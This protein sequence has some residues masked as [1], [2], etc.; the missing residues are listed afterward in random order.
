MASYVTRKAPEKIDFKVNDAIINGSGVGM[1]LGILASP[2]TVEVAAE[3]GQAAATVRFENIVNMWSRLAASAK[4]RAV[5]LAND[6]IEAQLMSMKFPGSDTAVPV[7]LPPGGLSA[8]P[9]GTLLGRPVITSEAMP[10]LGDSGDLILGDLSQYL[11]VVK[12]GGIRQDV[13]I[14]VFFDYDITAFRFV[15]RV[16]GQPYWNSPVAR[17]NNQ[18][19]KG[20]FVKLGARD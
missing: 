1:P 14:H 4:R 17:T 7:Y 18:A 11:T 10:V 19:T 16:G 5:W 3:S 2:G 6:D 20:F 9:Y 12:A 13:S 8:S 15:L